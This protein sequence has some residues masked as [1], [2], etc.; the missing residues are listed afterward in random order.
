M[1]VAL[2]KIQQNIESA[3]GVFLNDKGQKVWNL[4]VGKE[5][6]EKKVEDAHFKVWEAMN[7]DLS[8]KSPTAAL[9]NL[10]E[11]WKHF[12]PKDRQFR[13]ERLEKLSLNEWVDNKVNDIASPG[14]DA[15]GR[16]RPSLTY[17][18]Q[19]VQAN[20][21]KDP[22]KRKLVKAGIKDVKR[23][24]DARYDAA[25]N[26]YAS[27]QY[28]DLYDMKENF[29]PNNARLRT[30]E[31]K[32][33]NSILDRFKKDAK[34]KVEKKK[35]PT[36]DIDTLI[37][38][39]GLSQN[40]Y[41]NVKLGDFADKLS[42]KDLRERMEAQLKGV[43]PLD[44]RDY[45]ALNEA[46][47][48]MDYFKNDKE[49][50]GINT[51]K[52]GLKQ[53]LSD[54]IDNMSAKE[55]TPENVA[56]VINDLTREAVI[57]VDWY[58]SD[59]T[60]RNIQAWEIPYTSEADFKY[61]AEKVPPTLEK[62]GDNLEVDTRL[63]VFHLKGDKFTKHRKVW[64]VYGELLGR[65]DKTPSNLDKFGDKLKWSKDDGIFY[66]TIG[67]IRRYYDRVGEEIPGTAQR[68]K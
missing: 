8:A 19:L 40:D 65:P 24:R 31:L 51:K 18:D 52:Q 36:T 21:I 49:G 34:A 43:N 50:L 46:I 28:K 20:K 30:A 37:F 29:K 3:N 9:E 17:D 11:N 2:K 67:K 41:E 27:T 62:Y 22:E 15:Q 7:K 10:K 12:D 33:I 59:A 53:A 63:K 14:L 39:K 35:R 26:E 64:N 5:I 57:D 32:D 13:K 42:E 23:E 6:V 61:L 45:K 16:Q 25:Y 44:A 47:R 58:R 38:L 48:G 1:G 54:R 60:E 4:S 68:L 55:R 56:K 66:T